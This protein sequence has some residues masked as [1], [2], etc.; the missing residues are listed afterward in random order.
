[1]QKH[2]VPDLVD[3][4][5]SEYR[6]LPGHRLT[7]PQAQRLFQVGEETCRR[8][9][10]ALWM[11]GHVEVEDE[12]IAH[13][14]PP[15]SNHRTD[16]AE[17]GA[18]E[19]VAAAAASPR[20]VLVEDDEAQRQGVTAALQAAGYTVL[21]AAD[22]THGTAIALL[23]PDLILLDIGLP[24]G[25]GHSIAS[26]IRAHPETAGIPI[27]F[28]SARSGPED[29]RRADEVGATYLVKPCRGQTLIRVIGNLLQR[30]RTSA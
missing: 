29:L 11:A 6:D 24:D 26:C 18:L 28:L 5:W 22:A 25:D 9:I 27:V 4:V 13:R 23:K 7:F 8:T 16:P 2:D 1:M 30:Q 20:I 15:A 10:A 17:D 14:P 19:P 3:R 21:G 12:Q